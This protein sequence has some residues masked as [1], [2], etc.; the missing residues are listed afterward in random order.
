M[1]RLTPISLLTV[2]AL[3]PMGNGIVTFCGLLSLLG[4][5]PHHHEESLG[6]SL[7]LED[8]GYAHQNEEKPA[9]CSDYCMIDLPEATLFKV[10]QNKHIPFFSILPSRGMVD[11]QIAFRASTTGYLLGQLT[12]HTQAKDSSP[13]FTGR[14]LL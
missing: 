14:F 5:E 12:Y 7:C 8:E 4:S 9:P 10:Q 1:I 11:R 2:L 13:P 3:I 6:K